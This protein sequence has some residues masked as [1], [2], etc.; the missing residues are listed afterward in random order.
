MLLAIEIPSIQ[1]IYSTLQRVCKDTSVNDKIITRLIDAEKKCVQERQLKRDM[2]Y[3]KSCQQMSTYNNDKVN[4]PHN[5]D[6]MHEICS[7][8]YV[9]C[10]RN[11]TYSKQGE[12]K[13][14]DDEYNVSSLI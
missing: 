12:S 13:E 6:I 11:V 4:L 2:L 3:E 9:D 14:I 1:S 8:E 10:T 5:K 7:K